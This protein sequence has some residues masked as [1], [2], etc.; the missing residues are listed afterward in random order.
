MKNKGRVKIGADADLAVF[1]PDTVIDKGSSKTPRSIP[2]ASGTLSSTAWRC[3][4]TAS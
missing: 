2:K 4:R 3:L 1:N